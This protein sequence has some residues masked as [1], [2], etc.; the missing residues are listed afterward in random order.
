MF[1]MTNLGGAAHPDPRRELI[2]RTFVF[3]L[4]GRGIAVCSLSGA[5]FRESKVRSPHEC[6]TLADIPYKIMSMVHEQTRLSSNVIKLISRARGVLITNLSN[7]VRYSSLPPDHPTHDRDEMMV[8]L[9]RSLADTIPPALLFL[10]VAHSLLL[11]DLSLQ[12]RAQPN[13]PLHPALS[14]LLN[15]RV[16][17]S[18][19]SHLVNTAHSATH[20][21]PIDGRIFISLLA[22]VANTPEKP[23]S[24][25][26][27]SDVLERATEIWN[28]AGAPSIDI[29]KFF[30]EFPCELNAPPRSSSLT[31]FALLPFSNE[32][33]DPLLGDLASLSTVETDSPEVISRFVT[34]TIFSDNRHWHSGR[35]ILPHHLGGDSGQPLDAK[36]RYRRLKSNQRFMARMQAQAGT[37]TGALGA[38]LTQQIITTTKQKVCILF[39]AIDVH[40]TQ[41][42]PPSLPKQVQRQQPRNL[43]QPNLRSRIPNHQRQQSSVLLIECARTSKMKNGK[44][45]RIRAQAGGVTNSRNCQ[46]LLQLKKSWHTCSRYPVIRRFTSQAFSSS[47]GCTNLTWS[48]AAG[49]RIRSEK[50]QSVAISTP[51][52]SCEK[53]KKFL[54]RAPFHQTSRKRFRLSS[55][56][57]GLGTTFLQ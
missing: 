42:S 49:L 2:Q 30:S 36:Q 50:R 32:T 21:I 37:L 24:S 9:A 51:S 25:V 41:S 28:K 17:P 18:L 55:K 45:P 20:F 27:G 4:L 48:F 15:R 31:P 33:L 1:V 5:E 19:F 22:F 53:S 3:A 56:H 23:L 46:K 12:N 57:W 13:Q 11:E 54:K 47:F 43:R 6:S 14:S 40:V 52:S 26:L 7:A 8:I 35:S 34:N 16:L 10:F 38:S 44:R 29:P 39:S